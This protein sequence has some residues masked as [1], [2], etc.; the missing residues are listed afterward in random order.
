MQ[1]Q[2]PTASTETTDEFVDNAKMAAQHAGSASEAE[3][4]QIQITQT[5]LN[6]DVEGRLRLAEQLVEMTPLR[7]SGRAEEIGDAVVYFSAESGTWVT[8]QVLA[9][10]GGKL[11]S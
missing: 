11:W 4:L 2:C 7:R 5:F 3:Q 6:N 1:T 8:G 9:V 10:D